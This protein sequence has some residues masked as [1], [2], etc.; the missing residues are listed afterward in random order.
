[1]GIIHFRIY[2]FEKNNNKQKQ[3]TKENEQWWYKCTYKNGNLIIK[4]MTV[5]LTFFM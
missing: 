1:M 5:I 4:K 3:D 2:H